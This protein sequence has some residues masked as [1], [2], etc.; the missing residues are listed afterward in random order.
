[1]KSPWLPA[2]SSGPSRSFAFWWPYWRWPQSPSKITHV[3]VCPPKGMCESGEREI[4]VKRV[5]PQFNASTA[6][7]HHGRVS[8]SRLFYPEGPFVALWYS[9]AI[10]IRRNREVLWENSLTAVKSFLSLCIFDCLCSRLHFLSTK[11][12]SHWK[13]SS[14]L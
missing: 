11:V 8:F 9:S 14:N 5:F 10:Y 4:R 3:C 6:M 2:D 1:M 13:F 12:S 7:W